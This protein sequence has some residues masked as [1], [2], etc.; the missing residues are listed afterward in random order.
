[1]IRRHD[2]LCNRFVHLAE[3]EQRF[4]QVAARTDSVRTMRDRATQCSDGI[5]IGVLRRTGTAKPVPSF[6][7][8][9]IEVEG[10]TIRVA[11]G[12]IVSGLV[13]CISLVQEDIGSVH[14]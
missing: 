2:V 4:R 11:R 8:R 1:V 14:E 6:I 9:W 10:S 5:A 13:Q 12:L 3:L 7:Q